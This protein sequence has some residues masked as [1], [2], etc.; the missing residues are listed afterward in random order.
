MKYTYKIEDNLKENFKSILIE[1]NL[2]YADTV[3]IVCCNQVHSMSMQFKRYTCRRFYF[4]TGNDGR[5]ITRTS[6]QYTI[7]TK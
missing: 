2:G 4:V 1:S 7:P 3:E 6:L 5:L